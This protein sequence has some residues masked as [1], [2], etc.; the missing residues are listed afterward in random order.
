MGN[1]DECPVRRC[2]L[3]PGRRCRPRLDALNL[4]GLFSHYAADFVGALQVQ[5]E[6]LS[7]PE[8]ARQPDGRVGADTAALQY[9]VVDA[10]HGNV[11]PLRQL[12]GGHAQ[13]LEKL[14]PQDFTG[15]RSPGWCAFSW[16]VF[17]SH[18]FTSL[19]L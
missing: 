9:D 7:R 13:W 18:R 17:V 5:P 3:S 12:V 10:R 14:F 1:E 4:G 16:N 19:R 2:G 6:L 11:K 15:M 8:E